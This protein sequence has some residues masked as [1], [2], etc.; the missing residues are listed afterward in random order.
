[1]DELRDCMYSSRCKPMLFSAGSLTL[2]RM[3]AVRP[4][5]DDPLQGYTDD[6]LMQLFRFPRRCSSVT[7]GHRL[8]GGLSCI[9][10]LEE[11]GRILGQ[12]ITLLL[13]TLR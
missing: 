8:S 11:L 10:G 4:P 3:Q 9:R 1:M 13:I 2:L 6:Q 7:H 5:P 12:P